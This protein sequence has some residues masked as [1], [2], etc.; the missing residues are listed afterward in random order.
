MR[1]N[2]KEKRATCVTVIKIL[3][4][5][6]GTAKDVAKD[7]DHDPVLTAGDIVH[8]YA[9]TMERDV[10]GAAAAAFAELLTLALDHADEF[11]AVPAG[12]RMGLL[13]DL[14]AKEIG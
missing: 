10:A 8:L 1:K 4:Q 6:A 7:H 2:A 14:A 5:A 11:A 12:D 13:K 9:Q 3:E